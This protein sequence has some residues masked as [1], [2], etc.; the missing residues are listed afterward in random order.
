MSFGFGFGMGV[1]FDFG[2]N[3]S[4]ILG[5]KF[6]LKFSKFGIKLEIK[7]AIVLLYLFVLIK[8]AVA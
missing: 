1:R 7:E 6:E 4:E 8:D 3:M 5:F 2:S